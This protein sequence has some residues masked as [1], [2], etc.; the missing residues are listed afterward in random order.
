[1][2]EITKKEAVE[3]WA[4]RGIPQKHW[5]KLK[6]LLED[7]SPGVAVN[8]PRLKLTIDRKNR[9]NKETGRPAIIDML[10]NSKDVE[11]RN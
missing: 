3:K 2:S 11:K 4:L 1:M 5:Q 6:V 8:W 10:E 7:D 9:N